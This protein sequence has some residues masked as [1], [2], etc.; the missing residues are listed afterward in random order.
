[1]QTRTHTLT[2]TRQVLQPRCPQTG[3]GS[4]CLAG[5]WLRGF[6]L[7]SNCWKRLLYSA[8]FH[9]G[10]FHDFNL[11][12]IAII[13]HIFFLNFNLIW[14]QFYSC[15]VFFSVII[16]CH[17]VM[18]MQFIYFNVLIFALLK[19]LLKCSENKYFLLCQRHMKKAAITTDYNSIIIWQKRAHLPG[20]V[21]GNW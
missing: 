20:K 17:G 12:L 21:L 14:A 9:H 4:T 15:N 3:C 7:F 18:S 13:N 10:G 1:M 19:R 16:Y 6:T 2:L 5:Q 11:L 8:L